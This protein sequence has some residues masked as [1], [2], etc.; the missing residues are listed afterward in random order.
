MKNKKICLPYIKDDEERSL[1]KLYRD[2]SRGFGSNLFAFQYEQE[3]AILN[4]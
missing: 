2:G 1:Q 3:V 4:P